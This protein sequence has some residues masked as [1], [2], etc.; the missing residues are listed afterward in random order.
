MI[1]RKTLAASSF[2]TL[3]LAA[4]GCTS[5][6]Q[7]GPDYA[8]PE[9]QEP[10]G[11]TEI[12]NRVSQINANLDWWRAFDDPVLDSL[13]ADALAQNY[14]LAALRANLRKARALRRKAVGQLHPSVNASAS[15]QLLSRSENGLIPTS[16]VIGIEADTDLYDAGFDAVWEIVFGGTHRAIE[17][18]DARLE[19]SAANLEAA[20]LSLAAEI[21]RTYI[22]LIAFERQHAARSV[23]IDV[24]ERSKRLVESRLAVGS[25]TSSDVDRASARLL[26]AQASLPALEAEIQ[27]AIYRLA[28]LTGVRPDQLSGKINLANLKSALPGA[29]TINIGSPSDMLRTRPDVQQAERLLAAETADIGV[30]EADLLPRL[31]LAATA[32]VES[33]DFSDLFNA[34]SLAGSV[35]P[36]LSLPLFGRS[37]LKAQ[38]DAERAEAEAALAVYQQT[39]LRALEEAESAIARYDRAHEVVNRLGSA[40][41]HAAQEVAVSML[42]YETGEDGYSVVLDS[43]SN[44]AEINIELAEAEKLLRIH[45]VSLMK[46]VGGMMRVEPVKTVKTKAFTKLKPAEVV[47]GIGRDLADDKPPSRA[48]QVIQQ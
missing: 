14:D 27:A 7:A 20:Q 10:D 24:Q 31:T 34:A 18:A 9:V 3:A 16:D 36:R 26:R 39:I 43:E 17:A 4:G 23:I 32:G 42:R 11:W 33:I 6:G 28:V 8:R 37:K 48:I 13:V 5:F 46:A 2:I 19:A 38:I 29:K 15:A 21:A 1:T 12:S 22:E 40:H 47:A 41:M 45:A 44:L 30:A 35:G 25:A